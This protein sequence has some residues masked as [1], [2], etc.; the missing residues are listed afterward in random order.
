MRMPPPPPDDDQLFASLLDS[1]RYGVLMPLARDLPDDYSPWRKARFRTPPGPLAARFASNL[2][3]LKTADDTTAAP[4]TV[5]EWWFALH[6]KRLT[7]SRQIPDLKATDGQPLRFS[8]TDAVLR[9]VDYV[10]AQLSGQIGFAANVTSAPDR[11]RYLKTALEEEAITSSQLEGAATTRKAAK[12]LLRSARRPRDRSEQMIVNNYNALQRVRE[13]RDSPLSPDLVRELHTIVTAATLDNEADAGRLQ[14]S[15][16]ERVCVQA[17]P[18]G[19]IVHRPPPA[20]ELPGRLEQLC[21]F[22][23]ALDSGPYMPGVLRALTVHFMVS[24]DHYFVD[25]NGR[26]ARALFYWSMLHQGYWL[27]EY[28]TV[29]TILRQAPAKYMRSFLD[30]EQDSGDLTYFFMYH[31]GV[32]RRAIDGLRGYITRTIAAQRSVRQRLDSA[33]GEFNHRQFAVLTDAL[34]DSAR[35]FSARELAS[36]FA[37]SDETGRHD[38]VDLE[39]RALLQRRRVGHRFVWTPV[40]DLAQLLLSD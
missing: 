34:E 26:T 3:R 28:L 11:E 8:L 17:M 38:L 40:P 23:N 12:Q 20:D 33:R 14:S 25:G 31:L 4:L 37:V 6:Q 16:E 21:R 24:H 1:G 2:S 13:L 39:H 27:S 30:T 10:T 22:A 29:S 19:E 5:E 35:E 32:I 18:D 7:E 15:T 36:R 9:E